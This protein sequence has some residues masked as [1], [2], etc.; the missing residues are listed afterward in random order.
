M[1]DPR[2]NSRISF[3]TPSVSM[4]RASNYEENDS[5]MR[6][7]ANTS[8][9]DNL[10]L[11]P[12]RS[13]AYIIASSNTNGPGVGGSGGPLGNGGRMINTPEKPLL[14]NNGNISS[15]NGRNGVV[16]N[17]LSQNGVS[18]SANGT[19]SRNGKT[20]YQRLRPV[21][22]RPKV[23]RDSF[24][25]LFNYSTIVLSSPGG[26]HFLFL[27]LLLISVFSYL[28]SIWCRNNIFITSFGSSMGVKFGV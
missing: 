20:H 14:L 1:T 15:T 2:S 3:N 21:G 25:V 12:S 7:V 18:P 10:K 8:T 26:G 4:S 6:G 11:F 22:I 24:K 28:Y 17:Q 16:L 5:I 27:Y 9:R 13:N 19:N 23:W